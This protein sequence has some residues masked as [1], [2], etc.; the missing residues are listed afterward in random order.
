M[1]TF[2]QKVEIH[3]RQTDMAGIT[4]FNE[5]FNLFHD[6]YEAWVESNFGSK[7]EWFNHPEWAVPLK[8]VSCDYK[9]PLM[10]FETYNLKITLDEVGTTT[11]RLKTEIL[12]DSTVCAE[13]STTHIF[14]DKKTKRST[15]IPQIILNKL[16]PNK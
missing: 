4:Y 13:L 5:V 14:L 12:K 9:A 1:K 7:K 8:N 16:S 10:P 6:A 3:F 2:E 11:F 15:P